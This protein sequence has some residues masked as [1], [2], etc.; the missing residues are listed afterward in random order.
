MG[1]C[2]LAFFAFASGGLVTSV[3][4]GLESDSSEVVLQDG[5]LLL[6]DLS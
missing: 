5:L 6:L 4:L 2:F 1:A 3:D